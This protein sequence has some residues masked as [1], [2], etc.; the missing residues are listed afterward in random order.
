MC[1]LFSLDV[2]GLTPEM[3]AVATSMT[4]T[5]MVE[6]IDQ[7]TMTKNLNGTNANLAGLISND[8]TDNSAPNDLAKSSATS[9][10]IPV[11]QEIASLDHHKS[12]CIYV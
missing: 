12:E 2:G 9:K 1:F 4:N 6:S 11:I 8:K 5:N 3:T 10:Q 7:Q